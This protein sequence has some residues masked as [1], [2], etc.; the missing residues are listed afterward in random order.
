MDILYRF[1]RKIIELIQNV[2]P[3]IR[4][5]VLRLS[6][7]WALV[8]LCLVVT[9]NLPRRSPALQFATALAASFV[10]LSIPVERALAVDSAAFGFAFLLCIIV[11]PFLPFWLSRL[12]VPTWIHQVVVMVIFYIVLV[13]LLTLQLLITG[14]SD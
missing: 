8:G 14:G 5:L 12:L 11:L 7:W 2:D 9:R 10:A 4:S 1:S 13:G 3:T 6:F